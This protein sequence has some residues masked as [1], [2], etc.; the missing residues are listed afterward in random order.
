MLSAVGS[1]NFSTRST[2]RDVECQ[3]F[4][5]TSNSALRQELAQ[6]RDAL[7]AFGRRVSIDS[8]Q[9]QRSAAVDI[10]WRFCRTFL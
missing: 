2:E 5:C 3:F 8:F 9:C 10:A 6:E 7:F 4:L 1:S